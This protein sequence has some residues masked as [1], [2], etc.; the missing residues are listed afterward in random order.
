MANKYTRPT[1]IC[2]ISNVE[3]EGNRRD[4]PLLHSSF[5]MAEAKLITK[6]VKS[7]DF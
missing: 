6:S 7:Q 3:I 2:A 5:R 1:L 4:T